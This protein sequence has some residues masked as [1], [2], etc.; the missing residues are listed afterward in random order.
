[1]SRADV[2]D[3][4]QEPSASVYDDEQKPALWQRIVSLAEQSIT[5]L[6]SQGFSRTSITCLDNDHHVWIQ[7]LVVPYLNMRYD[8]TDCALMTTPTLDGCEYQ[9]GDLVGL[10]PHTGD[11]R[12]TFEGF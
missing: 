7:R 9:A 3:D 12:A 5:A 8:R 4:R 11:F 6:E 10:G 1:M 2:I